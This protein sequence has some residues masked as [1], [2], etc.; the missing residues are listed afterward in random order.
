LKKRI[1]VFIAGFLAVAGGIPRSAHAQTDG[2]VT[3]KL[4][5]NLTQLPSDITKVAVWCKI[6]TSAT[7]SARGATLQK[8]EEFV[9]VGGQVVTTATVVVPTT[10]LVDAMGKTATYVCTLTG[11]SQSLQKWDL[12]RE[13]HATPVFRLKPTPAEMTDTFIW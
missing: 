1:A 2:A 4:P 3:F 10:E 13:D 11:F 6:T 12:F 8:Q 9:P 5:L 7:V